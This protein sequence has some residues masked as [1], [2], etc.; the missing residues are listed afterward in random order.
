MEKNSEKREKTSGTGLPSPWDGPA[1]RGKTEAA[2]TKN[3]KGRKNH[4]PV[5]ETKGS[6][7]KRQEKT[8]FCTRG[9]GGARAAR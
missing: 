7:Q 9:K 4:Q 3:T 5:I 6:G 2:G 1:W 8:D